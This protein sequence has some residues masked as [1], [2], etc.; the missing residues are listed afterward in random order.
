MLVLAKYVDPGSAA[1][2]S[3][4]APPDSIVHIRLIGASTTA[5]AQSIGAEPVPGPV[6]ASVLALLEGIAGMRSEEPREVWYAAAV[7]ARRVRSDIE[8]GRAQ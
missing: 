7:L 2:L 6:G 3:D 4:L 8:L 1:G 5:S